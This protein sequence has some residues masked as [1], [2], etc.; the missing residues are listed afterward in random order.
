MGVIGFGGLGAA[1][2]GNLG[3]ARRHAL[4]GCA[5]WNISD[6]QGGSTHRETG[7]RGATRYHGGAHME[8]CRRFPVAT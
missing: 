1:M 4:E 5:V 7:E 6:P 8:E 3:V 2:R